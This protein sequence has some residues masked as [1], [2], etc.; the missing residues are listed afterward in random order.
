MA[1]ML[2]VGRTNDGRV[3]IGAPQSRYDIAEKP[4]TGDTIHLLVCDPGEIPGLIESLRRDIGQA[5]GPL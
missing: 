3:F 1:D 5:D 2:Q 4:L